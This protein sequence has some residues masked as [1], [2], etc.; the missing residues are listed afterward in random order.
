MGRISRRLLNEDVEDR[1]FEIFWEH[2]ASLSTS[3]LIREFLESL[4]SQTEQ[5]MIAKRLAIAVLLSRGY[6]Y[7]R[8]DETL[9]VSKSTVATV[10]RQIISGAPGFKRAVKQ[11]NKNRQKQ[12]M[13]DKL[14]K[15]LISIT[16]SVG[17]SS[18]YKVAKN[19]ASKGL[20]KRKYQRKNLA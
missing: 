5:V 15:L 16:P 10:D 20:A 8:I 4:L 3:G 14:E 18:I 6:T 11:V 1:L 2:L 13:W 12:E 9:K 17:K 7:Q 19:S